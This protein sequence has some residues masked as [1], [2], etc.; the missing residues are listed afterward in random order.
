MMK[1]ALKNRLRASA[2]L[3][4]RVGRRV[5]APNLNIPAHTTL[6]N[7]AGKALER[8]S[9]LNQPILAWGPPL[10]D[11]ADPCTAIRAYLES[12]RTI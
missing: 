7:G 2:T 10:A 4:I 6:F 5:E 9:E 3:E 8:I 1:K 11:S 12:H